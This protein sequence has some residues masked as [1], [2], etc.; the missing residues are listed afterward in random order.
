MENE[1]FTITKIDLDDLL[2]ILTDLY[3]KGVNFID[4]TA[5]LNG[6]QDE[7]GIHYTKEYMASPED[8]EIDLEE[9]GNTELSD[10]DLNELI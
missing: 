5:K 10:E 7:V 6:E 4:I 8:L 3:N 2:N 9:L 1:G